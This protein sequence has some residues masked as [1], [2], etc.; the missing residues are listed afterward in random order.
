MSCPDFVFV[1]SWEWFTAGVASGWFLYVHW[2]AHRAWRAIKVAQER[3]ELNERRIDKF[4][5]PIPF[6]DGP[7]VIYITGEAAKANKPGVILRIEA[8]EEHVGMPET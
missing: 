5:P 1:F 8:L 2:M 6:I 4:D 3:I 7:G